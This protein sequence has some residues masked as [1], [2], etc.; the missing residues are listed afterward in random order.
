MTQRP[1]RSLGP[2]YFESIYAADADPWRFAS[3]EYERAKYAATLAALP[4]PHYGRAFEIGCSIG[5]LT[6]QLAARCD[7]LLAVDLAEAPLAAA[8]ARCA[9]LPNVAFRRMAVP[10]DWPDGAFDLILLSEVVY[11][12][13]MAD[14]ARLAGRVA[15]ALAPGGEALLVHWTGETDYPLSGDAAAEG[16]IAAAGLPVI[17]QQRAEAYRL[18]LLRRPP[19][20]G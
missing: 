17:R 10:G 9:G 11:Y 13:D 2:D 8:R 3:S 14:L 18:D 12:L 1:A 19:P 20:P 16:F 4:R 15:A 5:V 6:A 7:S